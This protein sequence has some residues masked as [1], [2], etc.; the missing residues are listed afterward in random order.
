MNRIIAVDFDG[1]L[2]ENKWPSIGEPN[3]KLI[4]HLIKER[5][6]GVK[7]I[8]WTNRQGDLLDQA[9]LFCQKYGLDFDAVNENLPETIERFGDSRKVYATEYIDD[10]AAD[11]RRFALPFV[12]PKSVLS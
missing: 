4:K 8:L 1:T 2:A 5:A 6:E 10:K 11:G 7:I 3:R 9:V 12:M